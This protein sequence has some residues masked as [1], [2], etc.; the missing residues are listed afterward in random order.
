MI[1]ECLPKPG[2]AAMGPQPK[3]GGHRSAGNIF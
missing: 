3:Q 2:C 1:A